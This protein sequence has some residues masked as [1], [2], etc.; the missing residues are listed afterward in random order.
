MKIER[1]LILV[2]SLSVFLLASEKAFQE[3]EVYFQAKQYQKAIDAFLQVASQG[4]WNEEIAK[5]NLR[6]GQCY[7]ALEDLQNARKYF[8]IAKK[9]K[10]DIGSQAKLGL[11][12][13]DIQE[14][15]YDSAID[16]LTALIDEKP[17]KL[18]LA[19]AYYNRGIAYERKGWLAKAIEDY[20]E[21]VTLGTDDDS[22]L[23]SARAHLVDCQSQY[24]QFQQEEQNYLQRIQQATRPDA[25]RDLYHELARKCAQV[26]EID[27]GIEYEKKSLEYSDDYTYNAGA[28][29]N[30]AWRYAMKKDYEK[31]A[32]AFLKVAHDYPQSEYTPEAMLRAGDMYS[33]AKKPDEA[34]SAY[35]EFIDKYPNDS[36]VPSALMNIAWRYSDKKD[37]VKSAETFKKV[38]EQYPNSESAKEAL[39]RAGDMFSKAGKNEEAIKVYQE[40]AQK[41]PNDEDVGKALLDIAWRYRAIYLE[42]GDENAKKQKEAMLQEI[43]KRFPDTEIGY[44]ALGLFYEDTGE[45]NKAIEAYKK[46]AE[47]NGTQKDVAL[48]G[49]ATCYY[50]ITMIKEAHE[51]YAKLVEECPDSPL[52]PNATFF[53]GQTSSDLGDYKKAIED[54]KEVKEKYPESYYAPIA[55]AFIATAYEHLYDY[56]SA[57]K[58]Y[59]EFSD[60]LKKAEELPPHLRHLASMRGV[61]LLRIGACYL[62]LG[63]FDKA[64]EVWRNIKKECPDLKWVGM[65]GD[66]LADSLEKIKKANGGQFPKV[67]PTKYTPPPNTRTP[68]SGIITPRNVGLSM[69]LEGRHIFVYGTQGSVEEKEAGLSVA[70]A[71]QRMEIKSSRFK[72]DIKADT[73]VTEKDIQNRP[74]ILIGTPGSN[75]IIEQ[76]K[77]KLPIKVEKDEIVVGNRV[78]KGKDVGVFMVAPNPLNLAQYIVVIEGLTPEALR[79]AVNIHHDTDPN[80]L[81]I[82]TDYLVYDSKSGGVDKPVLEEGFFIKESMDNWHPL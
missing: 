53:R 30:I 33:Q 65:V 74:L 68:I 48:F 73:E 54:Y 44:F 46:C 75:K 15:K 9:E 28:W 37:Y 61:V 23:S 49:V 55:S 14:E 64:E 22:L 19:Y 25:I 71:L 79:Y 17:E 67:T 7:L 51:Y 20:Q 45:Y 77:D 13:C 24:D 58:E 39:L 32:D 81:L 57:L 62:N 60:V 12:L 8:G 4:G 21:A 16:S 26:G 34:I 72:P 10:G 40:F 82:Q 69:G 47:K 70:Q 63:Q 1:L 80:P 2:F 38:A 27:K 6:L 5:A 36:R 43:A 56:Q 11:A 42:T 31:A 76:I 3:G 35:Q 78:Y 18:T 50:D 59:L 66:R 41:Y 52:V 29:M